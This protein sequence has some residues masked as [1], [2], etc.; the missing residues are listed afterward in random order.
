MMLVR[1]VAAAQVSGHGM[2]SVVVRMPKLN[3]PTGCNPLN[4]ITQIMLLC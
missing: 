2:Q 4:A 1:R 3:P